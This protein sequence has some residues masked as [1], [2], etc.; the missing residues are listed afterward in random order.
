MTGKTIARGAGVRLTLLALAALSLAACHGSAGGHYATS[1]DSAVKV[2]LT[3]VTSGGPN[4]AQAHPSTP[5]ATSIAYS[6]TYGIEAPAARLSGLMHRHQAICAAAGPATCQ[7][8]DSSFSETTGDTTATLNLRATPAWLAT[9][10][11]GLEGDAREAGGRI[12]SNDVAAEDLE[13]T[14]IDTQASLRAQTTL[15][16]RLQTLLAT[17]PGK[18][19]D[20]LALEKELA[21]VQGQL[22]A[23]QSE[24][25]DLNGRVQMSKLTINYA[26]PVSMQRVQHYNPLPAAVANM[27]SVFSASL[28]SIITVLAALA[29]WAIL[30]GLGVAAWLAIRRTARRP[31]ASSPP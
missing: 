1:Q 29:P 15:R 5:P 3:K 12:V 19:E 11:A 21:L 17:R 26:T 22:D 23:T 6:Y 27:G 10:R 7:L 8:L 16:D 14:I 30:V 4:P 2:D 13:R 24:L 25:A 31:K 9:F 20:L 18:L 28:A